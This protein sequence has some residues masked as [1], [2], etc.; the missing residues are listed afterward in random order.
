MEMGMVAEYENEYQNHIKLATSKLEQA[1][2]C[3]SF[4]ERRLAASSAERAIEAA[5][6]S[7]QLMELEGRTLTAVARTS[8]TSKLRGYRAEIGDLKS[9]LKDSRAAPVPASTDCIREELFSTGGRRDDAG[10][11][12]RMLASNNER[13]AQGTSKLKDAHALT[14][15]IEGTAASILGDL[16]KQR[17]TL[18]HSR[19]TLKMAAEQLESSR[20]MLV[21]MARRAAANKLILWVIVVGIGCMILFV[22]WNQTAGVPS[23]ASMTENGKW[24]AVI[25]TGS[26]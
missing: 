17:E 23:A 24:Q 19:A 13:L 22:L 20:R 9:R 6:E 15:E 4:E 21:S 5:K 26:T 18:L 16:S 12:S 7:V 1:E 3:Q 10:E 11:R 14:L 25:R 2:R 8:L